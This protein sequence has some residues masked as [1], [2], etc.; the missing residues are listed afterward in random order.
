MQIVRTS[1]D[2]VASGVSGLFGG[3]Q[4]ISDGPQLDKEEIGLQAADYKEHRREEASR[5]E[6]GH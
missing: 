1:A 3:P 6:A 5:E 2:T 4:R